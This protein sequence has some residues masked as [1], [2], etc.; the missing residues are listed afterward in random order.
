[1]TPLERTSQADTASGKTKQQKYTAMFS[2]LKK[3]VKFTLVSG[4]VV[5]GT[6][7]AA[8]MLMGDSRA[9]AISHQFHAHVMEQI[10]SAIEDP[11]AL[12]SQII[13]LQQEYPTRISQVR[14]DLAELDEE[15]RQLQRDQAIAVRV[16]TLADVD[17]Q[18]LDVQLASYGGATAG[19][20]QLAAV[21]STTQG[22]LSF[23]RA[24]SRR[25]QIDGTR[26]TYASRAADADY[27]LT[28]LTKQRQRLADLLIR[29]ETE[30]AEFRTQIA[31]LNRQIEA[32]ERNDRLIDQLERYDNTFSAC[33][34]Y[35]ATS[36][37]NVTNQLSSIRSRQ[38]AELD[39]LANSEE[40]G[41]YEDLAR[42]QIAEEGLVESMGSENLQIEAALSTDDLLRSER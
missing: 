10:D 18:E 1:M 20:A 24:L 8:V 33:D 38:E 21:V 9:R 2:I 22:V 34:S 12:R 41:N 40:Q 29:L 27:S 30:Q 13:E 35:E 39:V 17:L 28:Y 26:G 36:L 14:G 16:V 11:H 5:G 6:A 31:S 7:A 19:Q 23:D 42:L 4:L 32:I 15:M 3:T 25:S 37:D